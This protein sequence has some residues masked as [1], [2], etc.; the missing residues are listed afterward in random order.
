M[1]H[2]VFLSYSHKDLLRVRRFRDLLRSQ[3]LAVWPDRT[4]TPGTSSWTAQLDQRL[5]ETACVLLF[6]SKNT[7]ESNWVFYALDFARERKIPVLPVLIDGEPGHILMV[8]TEGEIWFD[9]RWSRNYVR[10][11]RE[12]IAT[13]RRYSDPVV[14]EEIS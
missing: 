7:L 2:L 4:L 13:I 8:Q 9:L 3:G 14:V 11:L 12:L 1:G 10:E 5:D 6:L